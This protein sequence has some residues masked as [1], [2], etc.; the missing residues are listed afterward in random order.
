MKQQIGRVVR[1]LIASTSWRLVTLVLAPLLLQIG[2]TTKSWAED[3]ITFGIDWR[4]EAEYGGYYQA[5][6]NGIYA[7]HGLAVTIREGGPQVNHMQLLMAGRLDFNLGGGRAIEFVQNKL[8][9]VAIA[10]IFQKDPAVLIAHPGVGN[11]SFAALKG[12]PIEIAPDARQSWWRFLAAKYGY[13]DSQVKLYTFNMAPF[14]A[15]KNMIQ[16][17]YLGSEPFVI[18]QMG[19]IDP[20]VLL[21]ADGGYKGYGNI[22]TAGRKIVDEKPDLV[23]RFIDASVEGWYSYLYQDPAP[24]N[25]LIKEANPEMSDALLAYGRKM[26]IEHGIVDSGDALSLGIGAMTQERWSEFY[27]GMVEVGVYP[28][29]IDVSRAYVTNFVNHRTAIEIKK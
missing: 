15:D 8:P 29:G 5:V 2:F 17:G 19:G 4:A 28:A 23:R 11:D 14:L 24:A 20:V 1:R 9:Y 21:V 27:R 18:K 3:Q 6:A 12:K 7:K 26:M 10:A 16:Q 22:V 13:T 25:R